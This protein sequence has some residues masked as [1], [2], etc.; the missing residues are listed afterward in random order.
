MAQR[1]AKAVWRGGLKD[2]AGTVELGSGGFRGTYTA[3]S[4]F[5]SGLGTNPEELIGAAHAACFSM[6]LAQGLEQAGH[7]PESIE[8]SA[9]V[10][11]EKAGDGFAITRVL[12]DTRGTVPDI[13]E[14][15]F[16]R[17]AEIAKDTCPVS[18]ALAGTMIDLKAALASGAEHP[19]A[20][21]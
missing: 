15:E 14:D 3:K 4:R 17:Q 1:S 6:A 13:E 20:T 9:R 10:S 8:T 21:G 16:L 2:G 12:L 11:I 18:K 5:E 19:A 7:P